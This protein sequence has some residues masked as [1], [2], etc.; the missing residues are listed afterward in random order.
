LNPVHASLLHRLRR[1][2]AGLLALLLLALLA[3]GLI[4]P[5]FM[6]RLGA[7]GVSIVLCTPQGART[8][9][10]AIADVAAHLPGDTHCAFGLA[11]GMAGLPAGASPVFASAPAARPELVAATAARHAPRRH[12]SA[13]APPSDS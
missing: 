2:S 4:G 9:P 11:L 10:A 7:E 12:Y 6:P 13:R 5:G 8:V 1:P 3:R